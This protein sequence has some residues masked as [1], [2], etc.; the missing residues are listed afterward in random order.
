MCWPHYTHASFFIP[1]SVYKDKEFL[2][3]SFNSDDDAESWKA[4]FLRAGVFPKS[5]A[6][7]DD[8]NE[9]VCCDVLSEGEGSSGQVRVEGWGGACTIPPFHM[10]NFKPVS[11]PVSNRFNTGA[12]TWPL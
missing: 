9:K 4:S 7:T 1:R 12:F 11:K 5:E 3:L 10:A 2:E 6:S 8:G